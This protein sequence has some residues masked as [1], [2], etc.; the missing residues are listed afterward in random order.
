MKVTQFK[1]NFPQSIT[2]A[3]RPVQPL[4]PFRYTNFSN[5]ITRIT[6]SNNST[7]SISFGTRVL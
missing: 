2:S 5:T 7:M 6:T 1:S 3:V 4:L